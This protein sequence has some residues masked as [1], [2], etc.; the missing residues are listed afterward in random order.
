MNFLL[1][2]FMK[3]EIELSGFERISWAGWFCSKYGTFISIGNRPFNSGIIFRSQRDGPFIQ[4][5]WRFALWRPN[6]QRKYLFYRSAILSDVF[7]SVNIR[8]CWSGIKGAGS[9]PA[10]IIGYLTMNRLLE[11]YHYRIS[12]DLFYFLFAGG[13]VLS[14]GL[15]T[16]SSLSVKAALA[17]PVNSLR[18]EWGLGN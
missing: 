3:M 13:I 4:R 14:V 7:I 15:I 16:I 5:Q 17:N 1:T 12:L 18:D 6:I 11:N 2:G 10:W 9:Y 8:K